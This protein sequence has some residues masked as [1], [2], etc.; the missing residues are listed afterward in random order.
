MNALKRHPLAKGD[1]ESNARWYEDRRPGLGDEFLD[2]VHHVF[3]AIRENPFRF[4]IRFNQWRRANLKRFPFAVFF[5]VIKNEVVVFAV[6]YSRR[7]HET[8]LEQ[9]VP[10]EKKAS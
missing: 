2:E 3:E 10:K 8:I 1:I 5:Q 6:L 9:R 7:E 4:G